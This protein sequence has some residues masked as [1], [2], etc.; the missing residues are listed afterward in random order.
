M[1]WEAWRNLSAFAE[2]LSEWL[3]WKDDR[4]QSRNSFLEGSTGRLEVSRVRYSL[5]SASANQNGKWD[6]TS[7]VT[8]GFF[9]LGKDS[10]EFPSESV[11][12]ASNQKACN[13]N[14][15][16]NV[17]HAIQQSRLPCCLLGTRVTH[18]SESPKSHKALNVWA[19]TQEWGLRG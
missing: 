1:Y 4:G 12:K 18:R 2:K 19:I 6:V 16:L 15:T 14:T 5:G 8:L 3:R 17:Q 10:R 13:I 11:R 9:F 7:T